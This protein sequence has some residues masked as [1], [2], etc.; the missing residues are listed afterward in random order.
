MQGVPSG[1]VQSGFNQPV[2]MLPTAALASTARRVAFDTISGVTPTF[3]RERISAAR[4]AHYSQEAVIAS[5]RY[6]TRT[7]LGDDTR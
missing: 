7:M 1:R 4:N 6:G 2:F 5:T 3:G